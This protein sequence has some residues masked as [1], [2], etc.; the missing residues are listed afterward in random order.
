M[1]LLDVPHELGTAMKCRYNRGHGSKNLS[2]G[3]WFRWSFLAEWDPA[4][5]RGN[6]SGSGVDA[7]YLYARHFV[8]V[9]VR[10]RETGSRVSFT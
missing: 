7:T 5:L 1:P 8:E 3:Q 10:G 9:E 2:R 6:S 4:R